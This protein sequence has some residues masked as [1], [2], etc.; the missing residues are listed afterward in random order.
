MRY[1]ILFL[2]II[3][4]IKTF[5]QS[6]CYKITGLKDPANI[7]FNKEKIIMFQDKYSNDRGKVLVKVY[8][9]G[10]PLIKIQR[11]KSQIRNELITH[12]ITHS[13]LLSSHA[14]FLQK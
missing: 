1:I 3:L 8:F 12:L 10:E 7:V 9:I 5:G 13:F 2:A 6:D 14:L 4:S 11:I